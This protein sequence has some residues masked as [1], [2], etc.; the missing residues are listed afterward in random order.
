[1][2]KEM[3]VQ[4]KTRRV[5]FL[6]QRFDTGEI[7]INYVAG[8]DNGAALVLIPAQMGTWESY[9]PVLPPLSR[10][11]QVYAVDIR[12]HGK[13]DWTTGDYSWESVG[14]DMSAFLEQVVQRP[15]IISGNSS[16]GIIALWCAAHLPEFVSAIVLEDAPVFS[17]EMPRFRD[18]DRY[19]YRGL[20]H[21]V[22]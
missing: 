7:G 15:A 8:P 6:E 1:M 20:E 16:G 5:G 13:S 2:T 18:R 11:F 9:E 22:A 21:L 17:V 4:T 12:G 14:R 10:Q 3:T 19:V